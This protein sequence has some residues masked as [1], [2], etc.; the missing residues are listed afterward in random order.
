MEDIFEP[1]FK[2]W[3][4]ISICV[5]AWF[6]GPILLFLLWLIHFVFDPEENY[7]DKTIGTES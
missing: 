1:E 6:F 7:K 2:R 3:Q 4:K 5:F